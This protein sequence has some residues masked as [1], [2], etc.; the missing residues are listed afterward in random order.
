MM[1]HFLYFFAADGCDWIFEE[2]ACKKRKGGC[3]I[4]SPSYPGI[5]PPNSRCWYRIRASSGK[6]SQVRLTFNQFQLPSV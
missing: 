3:Q 4:A 1:F 6:D 5:Y 2:D